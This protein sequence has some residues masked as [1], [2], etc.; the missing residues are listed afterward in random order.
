ML[1][2]VG[3]PAPAPVEPTTVV[4]S[5]KPTPST[6]AIRL[7]KPVGF[8]FRPTQFTFLG[9]RAGPGAEWR[10]MSLATSPTREHLEYAVRVSDSAF[11]SAFSELKEGDTAWVRGPFGQFFL[12]EERPAVL[13]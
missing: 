10:P 12:N 1:P 8:Q 3:A 13:L 11:K 4:A 7:R 9:L 2:R 6:H 5:W